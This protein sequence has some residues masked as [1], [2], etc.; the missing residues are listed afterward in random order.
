M[1]RLIVTEQNVPQ[2]SSAKVSTELT[3]Q[4]FMLDSKSQAN[5]ISAMR[6]PDSHP[7]DTTGSGRNYSLKWNITARLRA[8]VFS[9]FPIGDFNPDPMLDWQWRDT[10]DHLAGATHEQVDIHYLSHLRTAVESVPWHDLWAGHGPELVGL[11]R[12]AAQRLTSERDKAARVLDDDDDYDDDC[13]DPSCQIC[14]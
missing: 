9:S 12:D 7:V 13:G 4:F 8:I 6:G 2:P 14:S 3:K 1:V 5:L 10:K 11:L